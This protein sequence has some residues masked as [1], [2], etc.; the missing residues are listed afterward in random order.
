MAEMETLYF[1]NLNFPNAQSGPGFVALSHFPHKRG[2][3]F[4]YNFYEGRSFVENIPSTMTPN[5][6]RTHAP[7]PMMGAFLFYRT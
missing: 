3:A 5:F 6:Y 7:S 2:I 1:N 4:E